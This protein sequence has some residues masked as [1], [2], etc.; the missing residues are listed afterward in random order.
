MKKGLNFKLN[1]V[2]LYL[3][4]HYFTNIEISTA[5]GKV[6]VLALISPKTTYQ[7]FSNSIDNINNNNRYSHIIFTQV[8]L[9]NFLW[10]FGPFEFEKHL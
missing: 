5:N 1:K 4:Q 10:N 2:G 6:V 9:L 3:G 8:S 7:M